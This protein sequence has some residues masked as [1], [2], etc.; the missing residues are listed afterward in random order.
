MRLKMI[1]NSFDDKSEAIINPSINK[2]RIKCDVCIVTFSNII[3]E[4]VKKNFNIKSVGV[5]CFIKENDYVYYFKYGKKKIAIYMTYMGAPLSVS[6]LEDVNCLIDTNKF[7]VFGSCG[8]LNNECKA[9]IIIPTKAYRDERTSYH[10][11]KANNYI[12]IKNSNK[13]AQFMKKHNIPYLKGKVWTTDAFYRETENNY[14]KR[15]KEGCLAVDMECSAI[16]AVCDFRG[17][18]LYYFLT[19]GDV[20]DVSKWDI[21]NLENA[22][23][24][25]ANFDIALNLAQEI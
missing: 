22:N 13:V 8:C 16:Q 21:S 2:K 14:I 19:S 12:T 3:I 1:T 24:G 5:F 9:K 11:K 17:W 18:D 7:I 20:L 6:N 10:Y 25:L 23:H 15:K 4:Y